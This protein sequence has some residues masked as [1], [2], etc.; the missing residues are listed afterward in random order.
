MKYQEREDYKFLNEREKAQVDRD[1]ETLIKL[2]QRVREHQK[3]LEA[4]LDDRFAS[5]C[6]CAILEDINKVENK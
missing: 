4:Y 2:R 6:Y 3:K 1:V 5:G